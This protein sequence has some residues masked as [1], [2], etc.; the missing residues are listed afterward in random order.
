[1]VCMDNLVIG[2]NHI[3]YYGEILKISNISRTWIFR[4]Q[5]IEKREFE[6]QM[7]A[8][9][10]CKTQYEEKETQKKKEAVR[11]NI[12][13]AGIFLLFSSLL[14]SFKP[15]ILGLLFLCLTGFLAY[16]A[17]RVYKREIIYP[18]QPPKEG[19]FPDKFGLGIEMNSGHK[20]T[21]T[22]IGDD[23]LDALKKLQNDIEEADVHKGIVYFNMG[24]YNITVENNDGVINTGDFA[25]NIYQKGG[26]GNL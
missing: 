10:N 6:K 8:Y 24:D 1:M 17:Y 21:F 16:V 4:F 5:N 12:I 15:G 18:H 25:N 3:K 2:C 13:G 19:S 7:L 9:K 14:F 11:N 20:V 23:G 26:Q 22:A